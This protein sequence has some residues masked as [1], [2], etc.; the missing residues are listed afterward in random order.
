[1]GII[2]SVVGGLTSAVGS[3]HQTEA[4]KQ[5]AEYQAD[6]AAINYHLIQQ[7]AS[8]AAADIRGQTG[9]MVGTQAARTKAGGVTLSGSPLQVMADTAAAGELKAQRALFAG[10][11][12]ATGQGDV[13][14]MAK[15]NKYFL[16]W[17]KFNRAG[18]A[19]VSSFGSSGGGG[20]IGNMV[21][22]GSSLLGGG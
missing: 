12:A 3:L 21:G 4:E 19:A 6:Q 1:M 11:V 14:E 13:M 18:A 10:K 16:E 5:S 17:N 20:Q 8:A 7:A 9:Q 2:G 15:F 22:G